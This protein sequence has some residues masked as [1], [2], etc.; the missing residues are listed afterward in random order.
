[1]SDSVYKR[2]LSQRDRVSVPE[3]QREFSYTYKQAR[4]T[5]AHFQRLHLVS[6]DLEGIYGAVNLKTLNPR[7]ITTARLQEF[8]GRLTVDD[9]DYLSSL[10]VAS[11]GEDDRKLV[12]RIPRSAPQTLFDLGLIHRFDG[13]VYLSV[14]AGTVQ[15]I[16]KSVKAVPTVKIADMIYLPI[17]HKAIQDGFR[18]SEFME[19]EFLPADCRHEL[20]RGYHHYRMGKKMPP[21]APEIPDS[22]A[23]PLKYEFL[24]AFL[25]RND[26]ETKE[27]YVTRAKAQYEVFRLSPLTP[28]ALCH[29][30]CEA[31]DELEG[32][33]LK[34]I[35][36]IRDI[37]VPQL[38]DLDD[39]DLF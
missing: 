33:T 27:D 5:F 37:L 8:A 14:T 35:R 15:R 30:V 32:M 18:V 6:R 24:E 7:C 19:N 36:E 3:I 17:L 29:A 12:F 20:L 23:G 4:E 9:V 38:E 21:P 26:L 28:P 31:V 22:A 1:M 2:F 25:R 39:D 13:E 34:Q 11:A 10:E 16:R